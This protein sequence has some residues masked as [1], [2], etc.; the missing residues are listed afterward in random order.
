MFE[1]KITFIILYT[2]NLLGSYC[3]R[4]CQI[5]LQDIDLFSNKNSAILQRKNCR[6]IASDHK[7][8][9][10]MQIDSYNPII[11]VKFYIKLNMQDP[12]ADAECEQD[13][14]VKYIFAF[15]LT[16][17]QFRLS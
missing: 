15:R 9:S 7:Q 6:A 10:Y 14:N 17:L 16:L 1:P 2:S 12:K 13:L 4:N 8:S 5:W 11:M 3:R